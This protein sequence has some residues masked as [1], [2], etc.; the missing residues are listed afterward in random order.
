[1]K[2]TLLV[3]DFD[4]CLYPYPKNLVEVMTRAMQRSNHY[5]S[6]R[7]LDIEKSTEIGIR[8]FRE[9]GLGYRYVCD[10]FSRTLQE[11][12]FAHHQTVHMDLQ[13]DPSLIRAFEALPDHVHVM[14]LTHSSHCFLDRKL[15][16]LGLDRFF[17]RVMRVAHEDYGLESKA[18]SMRG[19]V[20]AL[21][22]AQHA[23]GIDFAPEDIHMFEDSFKNLKLPHA[24]GWN[25]VLVHYGQEK[26]MAI[27]E[28]YIDL[29]AYSPA[30]VMRAIAD[31]VIA[32]QSQPMLNSPL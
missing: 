19:F 3:F 21:V 8:S 30:S 11:G 6:D 28:P 10:E 16:L 26:T 5:L 23:T 22:R 14:I 24:M 17:P 4:G 31:K 27:D 12:H 13:P 20:T 2:P 7:M 1:M 25:T 9:T 15:K 29:K 32:L 18:E